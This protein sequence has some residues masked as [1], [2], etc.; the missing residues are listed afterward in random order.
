MTREEVYQDIEKIFGFVPS[1][2][3]IV[4]DASLEPEWRLFK[5]IQFEKGALPQ[6]YRELIGLGLSAGMKCH[7][8][9]F[10]H[11]TMAKAYGAT[12]AEIEQTL[13]YAKSSSGWSAY[14]NGF[15]PDFEDFKEEILKAAEAVRARFGVTA[16]AA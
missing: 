11:M 5:H 1:L 2:F 6:K 9:V 15:Q 12:D 8:C 4:P 10:Y 3:Q 7:Y 14:I 16:K 13:H